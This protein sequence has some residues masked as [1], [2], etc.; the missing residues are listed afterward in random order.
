MVRAKHIKWFHQGA[1]TLRA[2]ARERGR[3]DYALPASEDWYM[4]P[5][6]IDTWLTVEEFETGELTVEHVP[7]EA[8]GGDDLVL[9]C[10]KCNNDAGGRFD[11]PAR[12]EQRIREFLSGQSGDPRTAALT[13]DGLAARVRM[14]ITGQTGMLFI[15]DPTINNPDDLPPL[16]EHMRELSETQN[17]GF[18]FDIAPGARYS[19]DRA[20][21]SWIRTAYLAAFALFGWKYILQ[22]ALDPIRE[23][24]MNPS[25]ITLPPLSMYAPDGDPSRREIWVIK[26]PSE[27]QSL[28][29]V[30]G[31]HS[32]FLP[33]PNDSR[34][35][36]ELASSLGAP[37]EG[38][39]TYAFT[40]T[41]FPWPSRPEHLLDPPPVTA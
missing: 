28:L 30:A 21:T 40:G 10:K 17:T 6:C 3:E 5:L 33:L 22:T 38:P 9:T 8:L 4:C 37:A 7:P 2:V 39:V 13:V 36:A 26:E 24:M 41:V 25:A 15:L 12:E 34:S 23:Q 32:V 20:R 31:Q 14:H 11:G 29:V 16:V 18:R 1:G 35:L 27:Y 19:P